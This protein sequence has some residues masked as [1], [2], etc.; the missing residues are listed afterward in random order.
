LIRKKPYPTRVWRNGD[1][2]L[3]MNPAEPS[4]LVQKKRQQ[5]IGIS[6]DQE[7]IVPSTDQKEKSEKPDIVSLRPGGAGA[8]SKVRT[9]LGRPKCG[10]V[11]LQGPPGKGQQHKEKDFGGSTGGTPERQAQEDQENGDQAVEESC[12]TSSPNELSEPGE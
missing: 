3:V 10:V 7:G 8:A 9:A 6:C 1:S 2:A 11:A 4:S 5:V 12:P